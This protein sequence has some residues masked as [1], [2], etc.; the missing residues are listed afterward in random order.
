[1]FVNKTKR[2]LLFGTLLSS[3]FLISCNKHFSVSGNQY[4][5]Y[6]IDQSADVDSSLVKYYLP[7]KKQMEVEMNRVIGRTDKQLTKPSEPET[8]MGN[9][10]SDAILLEGLKKDPEIQFTLSTKGGLRTTFPKGD[11]RVNDAFELMPFENEL[12]VLTLNGKS[13][14]GVIDFIAK[15]EGQPV[16]GIRMTIKNKKAYDV[17]IAGKP[18]DPE[19][20]YKLLTY[21]Y[22]ANGGDDLT[23]LSNPVESKIINKKVRDAIIDY[24]SEL[25]KAGKTINTELDGR[26]V[27]KN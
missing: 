10:F 7:Y 27:V 17:M 26:V 2:P 9:F 13:V 11:I 1:M 15:S 20:N 16:A 23:C 18:F 12:V 6:A 4:K 21:D 3:V 14:Q 5:E 19:K 8:L 25:T 22:L 24:I